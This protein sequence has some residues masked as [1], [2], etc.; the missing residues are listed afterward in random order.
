M[1]YQGNCV[2]SALYL[3]NATL[4]NICVDQVV[5]VVALFVVVVIVVNLVIK[6]QIRCFDSVCLI[7]NTI[8]MGRVPC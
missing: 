8:N 7:S 5:V 1:C 3:K 2:N 6:T 4:R